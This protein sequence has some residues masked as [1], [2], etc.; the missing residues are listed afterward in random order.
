MHRERL[1]QVNEEFR[2]EYN[3]S[4]MT[5]YGAQN[6]NMD[7]YSD[8]YQSDFD[9]KAIIIPSL[10]DLVSNDKPLSKVI[11]IENGQI[12]VKDI[13]VFFATLMKC[14]PAYVECLMSKNWVGEDM[15]LEI[16]KLM[17]QFVWEM[18][19]HFIKACYGMICEKH[20]ALQHPYPTLIEKIEKFGYDPKQL[21]HMLR[22]EKMMNDF[23]D[24]GKVVLVPNNVEFLIEVKKGSFSCVDAVEEARACRQR[25]SELTDDLMNE[26]REQERTSDA[27]E[28]IRSLG[29]EIT[30]TRIK[31]KILME[32]GNGSN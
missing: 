30:S 19:D 11:D 10:D 23:K 15:F 25:A 5:L 2:K 18:R 9:Y 17:P 1:M 8:G 28:K 3:V 21:H 16:R 31:E 26:Y 20:K 6:Y 22:I 7:I 32:A 13:R 12:D 27:V 24:T 4:Y 14:N 29:K